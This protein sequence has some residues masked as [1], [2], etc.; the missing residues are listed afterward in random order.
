MDDIKANVEAIG[1]SYAI[2][3]RKNPEENIVNG[4]NF[5]DALVEVDNIL[6]DEDNLANDLKEKLSTK[7]GKTTWCAIGDSI[8]DGRYSYWDGS[9]AR[10]GTDHE[11]Q[12]NY[13][14]SRIL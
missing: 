8:T 3:I 7:Y 1:D 12:Y 10:T 14:A 2:M 13:I 9:T 6:I 11:G 5:D 4:I